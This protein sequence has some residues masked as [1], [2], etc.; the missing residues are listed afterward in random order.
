MAIIER[1]HD[2]AVIDRDRRTVGERPVIGARRHPDIVDDQVQIF[3]G[4]D[5]ADLVFDLL[6]DLLG[7]LD[8]G[9]GGCPD[10]ELDHAAVDRRIEIAADKGEHDAAKDEK[11][12]RDD[13]DDDAA[14]QQ[15]RQQPDVTLAH[16]LESPLEGSMEAREEGPR[17]SLPRSWGRGREGPAEAPCWPFSKRPMVIGVRVR[18]R[19]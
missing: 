18:D 19:P 4:D 11:E 5:V 1:Y 6:E 2:H 17:L 3:F 14:G 13:R 10:M 16:T 8:A 9:A 15:H 12:D 7:D